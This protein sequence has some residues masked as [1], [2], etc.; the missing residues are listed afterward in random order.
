MSKNS[1]NITRTQYISFRVSFLEK[2]AIELTAK[3]ANLSTSAYA[4]KSALNQKIKLRFTPDE[5]QAYNT[6]HIYHRNFKYISNLMRS[7]FFKKNQIVIE[8]IKEVTELIQQHLKK[9]EQ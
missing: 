5:I 1:D 3:D 8:E 9:F 7:S 4:R 6:L 2:R